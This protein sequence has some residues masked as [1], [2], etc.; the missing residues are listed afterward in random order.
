MPSKFAF[1]NNVPTEQRRVHSEIG[2]GGGRE[3]EEEK[4]E[5]TDAQTDGYILLMPLKVMVQ[6]ET[7]TQTLEI[8][9]A[10]T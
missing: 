1:K 2:G 6:T 7:K 9:F 3:G 5:E 4:G 8:E 10:K